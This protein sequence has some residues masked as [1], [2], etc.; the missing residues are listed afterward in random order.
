[1]NNNIIKLQ[2]SKQLFFRFIYSLELVELKTLKTYIKTNLAYG[3]I[4]LFISSVK[5]SF[6]LIKNQIVVSIFMSIIGL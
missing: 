3:I 1:M 5:P 4:Y 6:F 2:K